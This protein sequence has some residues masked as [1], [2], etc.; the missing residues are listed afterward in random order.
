MTSRERLLAV[1]QGKTPDRVPVSCYELVGFDSRNFCNREPSYQ[2]VMDY[3]REKTDCICMWNPSGI[4]RLGLTAHDSGF[5]RERREL[6]DGHET[7]S[8]VV[9]HARTLTRRDRV[10]KGV[11]TNWVT[12]HLCKDT[13]DIDAVLSI[14]YVPAPYSDEDAP[15]ILNQ[16]GDHGILMPSLS[17]PAYL[18]MYTASAVLS[19]CVL[20]ICRQAFSNALCCH[21][22][23]IWFS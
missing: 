9:P 11:Y 10:I 19:I 15:P 13:D 2:S 21:I 17:D 23:P 14:P 12:E 7:T 6:P 16:L 3:I 1:L 8:T 5:A 4:E 20:P 22:L 18:A